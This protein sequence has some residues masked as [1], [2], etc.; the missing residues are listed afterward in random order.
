MCFVPFTCN[1]LA[2]CKW[3]FV[4]YIVLTCIAGNLSITSL[5]FTDLHD[6]LPAIYEYEYSILYV[7]L[8]CLPS[9][10]LA[11]YVFIALCA[12]CVLYTQQWHCS[13]ILCHFKSNL[14][15]ENT[16]IQFSSVSGHTDYF[17]L[18][19]QAGVLTT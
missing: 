9:L 17:N 5:F 8:Y 4:M 13:K 15:P 3:W 7:C 18:Q 19:T 10:R 16:T 6:L 11:M 14:W 1:I 2:T 12:S